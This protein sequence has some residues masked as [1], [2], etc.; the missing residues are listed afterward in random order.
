MLLKND[1]DILPLKQGSKI[2]VCGPAADDTGVANVL[3]GKKS[4]TGK[5]PMPWYKSTEDIGTGTYQYELGYG[6]TIE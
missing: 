3:V 1:N 4:F 6:L 2:Y 5:L